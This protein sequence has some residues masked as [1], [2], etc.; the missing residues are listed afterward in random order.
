MGFKFVVF[1]GQGEDGLWRWV[2]GALTA[3][4]LSRVALGPVKAGERA[5]RRLPSSGTRRRG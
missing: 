3:R 5:C 4:L 2:V 1:I